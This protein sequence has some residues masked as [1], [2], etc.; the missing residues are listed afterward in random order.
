MKVLVINSLTVLALAGLLVGCTTPTGEPN[1]TANGAL[2]GAATGAAIGALADWRAP[3]VG[4][5]IGAGAG[6]LAGALVGHSMDEARARAYPPP[7]PPPT[8]AE[9]KSMTR[10]AVGDDAIIDQ[11]RNTRAVYHLNADALIDLKNAGVSHKV[12][13]YMI[14][15]PTTVAALPPQ[16]VQAGTYVGAPGPDYVWVGGEWTWNGVAWVW[17]GGRWVLPPRPHAVWVAAY[18]TRGPYGWYRVGGYW[19]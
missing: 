17:V 10:A 5:A 1:N 4:A 2:G 15:T 8:I 9:I 11:M 16:P 6:L 12:L 14:N 3:G 18:W 19:R 13:T 7:P